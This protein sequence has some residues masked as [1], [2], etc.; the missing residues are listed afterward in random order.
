MSRLVWGEGGGI[1]TATLTGTN[2][3]WNRWKKRVLGGLLTLAAGGGCKQQLF[4]EP[5]DYQDA[6]KYG[7]PPRLETNPHEAILPPTLDRTG[8]GPATVLDPDRPARRMTLKECIAIALEQGNIGSQSPNNFGFKSDNLGGFN[9]NSAGGTDTVRAFALE[10]AVYGAAIEQAVSK[11]DARWSTSM[12]W[13]KVDQPVAAQFLSFQQQRDGASFSSRIEKP[14][15]T[16]GLANITFSTDYSKF[17]STSSQAGFVNPNY[18]PRLSFGFDQPL[19]RFFGVEINQLLDSHPG[20]SQAGFLYAPPQPGVFL[21][22]TSSILVT[23]IRAD[24]AQTQFEAQMNSLLVNVETAYWNLYSAYYN[25]YAQEEGLRQ[26][27]DGYR[28]TKARVDAGTDPSQ[29]LDQSIAQF[30]QFRAQVYTARGQ[31]LDAERQLRGFMGLLSSDNTRLVP[32]DE[33]NLAPY[34]PDF[35]EA[36][37]EAVTYRPELLAVRQELKI[38]QLLLR[39][40]R[41]DR[42]PDLRFNAQ[43]DIAGLGTRLDGPEFTG[44]N[45]TTQGNAF[46]SFRNDQFNS[47][48]LGLRLDVPIGFR[49]QNAQVRKAQLRL[50]G[51]YYTLRDSELKAVEY[52]TL[53]HRQV[54]QSYSVIGPRRSQREALQRFVDKFKTQIDIGRF[55]TSEYFNYLQVQRDLANAIAQEFQAIGNY[56]ASLA[57]LEYA[58]GTILRYNNI[59]IGDGPLP[60]WVGKRAADHVRE[61][62]EAALQLRERPAVQGGGAM[63]PHGVGPATGTPFL[64]E[65]PPFAEKREPLPELPKGVKSSGQP[66]PRPLPLPGGMGDKPI[67]P[68]PAGN[69]PAGTGPTASAP[70]GPAAQPLPFAQPVPAVGGAGNEFFNQEGTVT[71]PPRRPHFTAPTSSAPPVRTTE[72]PPI[73]IGTGVPPIPRPTLPLGNP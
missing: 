64:G 30:E 23:R 7:L 27:F 72:V 41:D 43:Y 54:V 10:P 36:A 31:V 49:D 12:T 46:T 57:Q 44:P 45:Q 56:N 69:P 33:P 32:I 63:Q 62:T 8:P 58:K 40:A 48:S 11:F 66:L 60:S 65:L 24:Q 34:M 53:Q 39:R 35:Y 29:Q 3:S 9:G 26:A 21:P 70:R 14:L 37:N 25:L 5:S 6:V 38:A 59:T 52:V 2:M 50:T 1:P 16:G 15:P 68:P 13:Q 19:L 22:G 17:S 4:M 61:R 55:T 42:R 18:T 20:P 51:S 67:G 28:F 73:S 47:W 71:L